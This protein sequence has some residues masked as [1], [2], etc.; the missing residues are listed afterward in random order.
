MTN[1]ATDSQEVTKS[2]CCLT[3]GKAETQWPTDVQEL[4][5]KLSNPDLK[6]YVSPYHQKASVSQDIHLSETKTPFKCSYTHYKY[7]STT[8]NFKEDG[9]QTQL[10]AS[11]R[12]KSI[13]LQGRVTINRKKREKDDTR[14]LS[15]PDGDTKRMAVAPAHG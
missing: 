8:Q 9:L 2:A 5:P 3:R 14:I 6:L 12:I 1:V 4:F 15:C 10:W 13:L 7:F 11:A